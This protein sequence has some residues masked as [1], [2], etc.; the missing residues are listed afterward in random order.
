MN[1]NR[2]SE[3]P[4]LPSGSEGADVEVDPRRE[5]LAVGGGDVGAGHPDMVLINRDGYHCCVY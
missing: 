2:I 5:V 4:S 3:L 1:M